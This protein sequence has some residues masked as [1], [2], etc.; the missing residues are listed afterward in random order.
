[1]PELCRLCGQ[2][3]PLLLSHILPAFVFKWKRESAGGSHLRSTAEPNL[4][5][6]DGVKLRWLCVECEEL[7]SKDER[8]FAARIFYPF[9]QDSS[10]R[11]P[12]GPWLLRFC[13][14]VSWRLLRL[15]LEK[16][17]FDDWDAESIEQCRRVE[18]VWREF[19]LGKRAHPGDYRQHMVPFDLIESTSM[20]SAAPNINRY[21]TRMIQ[22]DLCHGR[23][24]IF[25]FAKLGRFA[26]FGTVRPD[27][28]RWRGA[29]VASNEG[30]VGPRDYELPG[31]L[32][33]YLTD[34]ALA[35]GAALAGVTE[36]QQA[37]IDGAFAKNVDAFASSDAF[38]AMQ[39][40]VEMF[41]ED[42][43]TSRRA[44]VGPTCRQ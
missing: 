20:D 21:L 24:S 30:W 37:K 36:K 12:Y 44:T 8:A 4:R 43:F 18:I 40:D 5:V 22:M 41:G 7:F 15:A 17:E 34:K 23:T 9:L 42:A 19:L 25:T 31:A 29:A 1:M 27:T 28:Q 35:A 10:R 6:Q 2:D 11:H 32:W 26:I 39:A 16:N 38:R 33:G 13:C 3:K 14:S